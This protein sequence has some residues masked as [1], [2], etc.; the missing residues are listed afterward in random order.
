MHSSAPQ[1]PGQLDGGSPAADYYHIAPVKRFEVVMLV[2]VRN[3]FRTQLRK[4]LW[5]MFEMRDSYGQ[6]QP[7]SLYFFAGLERQQEAFEDAN[8]ADHV[9]FFEFWNQSFAECQTVTGKRI[10]PHRDVG[11]VIV[12]TTFGAKILERKLAAGSVKIRGKTIRLEHHAFGHV[13]APAVHRASENA[14]GDSARAQMRADG[15]SVRACSDN[16]GI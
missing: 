14:K 2:A 5:D 4:R 7:L 10:Q 13:I 16:G 6:H 9:R 8:H 3:V 11:V 12:D 15:K 1:Q